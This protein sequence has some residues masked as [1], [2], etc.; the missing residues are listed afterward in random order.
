M[1]L[2]GRAASPV[3]FSSKNYPY[4]FPVLLVNRRLDFK[5]DEVL[6]CQL[7]TGVHLVVDKQGMQEQNRLL[8]AGP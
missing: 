7:I 8:N 2:L 6:Y 5:T 1:F 4:S 3:N